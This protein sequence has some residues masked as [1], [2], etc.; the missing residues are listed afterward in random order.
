[1]KRILCSLGALVSAVFFF[2]S[3]YRSSNPLI[4]CGLSGIA[5]I[6]FAIILFFDCKVSRK[7]FA[8]GTAIFVLLLLVVPQKIFYDD[9]G[10]IVYAAITYKVIVWH[11]LSDSYDENGNILYLIGTS[12]YV[13]SSN[14]GDK[15]YPY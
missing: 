7:I 12:F 3:V 9:G 5:L 13:F 10:T 4:E 1:M 15:D 14:F 8:I 2:R 11:Q 6:V